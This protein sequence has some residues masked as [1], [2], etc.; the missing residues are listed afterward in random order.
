MQ[1][2]GLRGHVF[3]SID[4]ALELTRRASGDELLRAMVPGG[5]LSLLALS[6]YYAERVEGVRFLRPLFAV[7]FTLVYMARALV[8]S[9][10]AGRRSAELLAAY[11]VP[12][13][14]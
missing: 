4:R 10:W 3:V 6:V 13:P 12:K 9:R 5:V 2:E 1:S 7:A 14:H 8:L 11:R